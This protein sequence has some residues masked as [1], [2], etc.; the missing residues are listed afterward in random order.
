MAGE[1][2]KNAQR[3]TEHAQIGAAQRAKLVRMATL[4]E[5]LTENAPGTYY[6]D[7][8]CI[9][10]DQCRVTAPDFFGRNPDTCLSYVIKQ[11]VT[12]DEIELIEQVIGSC[13]TDS[14]GKDG[15]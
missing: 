8:S 6:V 3:R 11:P 2:P 7:A 14:I 13:A 12:P 1:K 15:A 4:S 9:D 10:C 5:R